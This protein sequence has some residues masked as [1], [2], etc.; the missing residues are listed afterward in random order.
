MALREFP[1]AKRRIAVLGSMGELGQHAAALHREV[2]AYA[3]TQEADYLI[4]VGPH[5]EAYLLGARGAGL[6]KAAHAFDAEEAAAALKEILQ[7]GDAVLIKGSRFM[8]LE[9]IVEA[10]G[11]AG[12][13]H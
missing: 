5:A 6:T 3:R 2:G 7:E 12:G 1:K 11:G 9:K 13:A 10:L 8:G 4:A